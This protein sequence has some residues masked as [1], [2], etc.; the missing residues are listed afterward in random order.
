MEF[1]SFRIKEQASG[2]AHGLGKD[3]LSAAMRSASLHCT[4]ARHR[5]SSPTEA[6]SATAWERMICA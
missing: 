2:H 5:R 4:G 3:G 6:A 1:G